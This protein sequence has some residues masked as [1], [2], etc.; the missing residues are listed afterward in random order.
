MRTPISA[1]QIQI[2]NIRR[3]DRDCRFSQRLTELEAG[4]SRATSLVSKLLRLAR[5]D[6]HET[7]PAPQPIDL[8]QLALDTSRKVG[9]LT[10][11]SRARTR[12]LRSV[13]WP[14]SK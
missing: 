12:P 11:A 2:D 6:A 8:V 1:L 14:I 13:R 7:V 10:S 5:Y 4:I 3:D 9:R